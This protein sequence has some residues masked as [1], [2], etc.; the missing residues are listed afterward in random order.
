MDARK[1]EKSVRAALP[2]S[3]DAFHT[4]K[5]QWGSVEGRKGTKKRS[6]FTKKRKNKINMTARESF[7]ACTPF[8]FVLVTSFWSSL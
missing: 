2:Y 7:H 6:I 5:P 3:D 8:F 4:T 1:K